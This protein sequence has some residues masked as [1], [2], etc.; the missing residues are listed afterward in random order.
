MASSAWSGRAVTAL[1]DNQKRGKRDF[2]SAY[3]AGT[4]VKKGHVALF[5]P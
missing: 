4:Y 1:T 5:F 2:L 3:P